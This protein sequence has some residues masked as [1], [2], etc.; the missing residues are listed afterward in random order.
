MP[1]PFTGSDEIS[2]KSIN[3]ICLIYLVGALSETKNNNRNYEEKE[4]EGEGE[5]G[6]GNNK[7]KNFWHDVV[8]SR[9]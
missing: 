8:M 5:R 3:V 4:E 7:K 1:A 9:K 2:F 6:G